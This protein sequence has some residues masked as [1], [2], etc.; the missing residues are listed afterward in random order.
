MAAVVSG[1]WSVVIG[2]WSVVTGHWSPITD[3][4]SPITDTCPLLLLLADS[5]F[6]QRAGRHQA[7]EP[8]VELVYVVSGFHDADHFRRDVAKPSAKQS[9]QR[10]PPG[11]KTGLLRALLRTPLHQCLCACFPHLHNL[12][13]SGLVLNRVLHDLLQPA[14]LAFATFMIHHGTDVGKQ[15]AQPLLFRRRHAVQVGNDTRQ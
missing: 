13:T 5:E 6:V 11:L 1:Q 15:L 2:Q 14:L 8:I 7:V 12:L 4:R 3:D 9:D 10:L